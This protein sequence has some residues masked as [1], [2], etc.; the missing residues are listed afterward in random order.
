[1]NLKQIETSNGTLI[2]KLE[3]M[4]SILYLKSGDNVYPSV[5]E[6]LILDMCD[7]D[8]VTVDLEKINS[9]E[10]LAI[11]DFPIDENDLQEWDIFAE[12]LGIELTKIEVNH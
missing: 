2:L 8:D 9:E 10:Y 1:M 11:V 6:G 3:P 7:L 12:D 5:I 4:T